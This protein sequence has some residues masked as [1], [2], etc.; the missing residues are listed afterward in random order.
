MR[1]RVY[2]LSK[3]RIDD[4]EVNPWISIR[5]NRDRE[6]EMNVTNDIT[7]FKIE[8]RDDFLSEEIPVLSLTFLTDKGDIEIN[9]VGDCVKR[10]I[11]FFKEV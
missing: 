2:P 4:E 11:E 8:L 10:L 7:G 9:L 1:G 3:M 5:L 6:L